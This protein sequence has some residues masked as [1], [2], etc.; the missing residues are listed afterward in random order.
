M[1]NFNKI[2]KEGKKEWKQRKQRMEKKETKD[3]KKGN[4]WKKK[5]NKSQILAVSPKSTKHPQNS[6]FTSHTIFIEFRNF[7]CLNDSLDS[8]LL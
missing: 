3:K 6:K 7:L 2:K 8:V 4:K 5:G 1:L